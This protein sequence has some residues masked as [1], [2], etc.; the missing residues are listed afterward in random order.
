MDYT[1]IASK[2]L[3]GIRDELAAIVAKKPD[4]SELER[5]QIRAFVSAIDNV[6]RTIGP[7]DPIVAKYQDIG[8]NAPAAAPSAPHTDASDLPARPL[9]PQVDRYHRV[10]TRATP[11]SA[12]FVECLLG[13]LGPQDK[14]GRVEAARMQELVGTGELNRM[15]QSLNTAFKREVREDQAA[16][17]ETPTGGTWRLVQSHALGS[18]HKVTH[19]SLAEGA[20][21]PLSAALD[22]YKSQKS[23]N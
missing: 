11:A 16:G 22:I 4:M 12:K 13:E 20:Y 5:R 17:Y 10:L 3:Q 23:A 21:D 15:T 6:D 9:D 2:A 19:Y 14:T 8:S 7:I 1:R 18:G